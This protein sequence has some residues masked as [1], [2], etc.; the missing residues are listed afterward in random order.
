[1]ARLQ[2]SVQQLSPEDFGLDDTDSD[3]SDFIQSAQVTSS[4]EEDEGSTVYLDP[5]DDQETLDSNPVAAHVPDEDSVAELAEMARLAKIENLTRENQA[6]TIQ[7]AIAKRSNQLNIAD[8]IQEDEISLVLHEVAA[9]TAAGSAQPHLLETSFSPG[10]IATKL[11]LAKAKKLREAVTITEDDL[12]DLVQTADQDIQKYPS[13]ADDINASLANQLDLIV[14]KRNDNL[15]DSLLLSA[16]KLA[17]DRREA[18]KDP[19]LSSIKKSRA[20]SMPNIEASDPSSLINLNT[21][22]FANN[23]PGVNRQLFGATPEAQELSSVVSMDPTSL[24]ALNRTAE[25][26]KEAGQLIARMSGQQIAR[27]Q[28]L[29]DQQQKMLVTDRQLRAADVPKVIDVMET[30]PEVGKLVEQGLVRADQLTSEAYVQDLKKSLETQRSSGVSRDMRGRVRQ[31]SAPVFKRVVQSRRISGLNYYKPP[32]FS[33]PNI[34][35]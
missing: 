35:A 15:P 7:R 26:V 24:A 18:I 33:R 22:G 14:E 17:Q 25:E 32:R 28:E 13:Q 29:S 1:M 6:R 21:P 19:N 23:R 2:Q 34:F 30:Y 10:D 31:S 20:H 11:F 27:F 16:K 12:F 5:V 3:V 4:E 9:E 8:A